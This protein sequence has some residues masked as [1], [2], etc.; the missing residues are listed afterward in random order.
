M[1]ATAAGDAAE[2]RTAEG[3][4]VIVRAEPALG[5][6]RVERLLTV[7]GKVHVRLLSYRDGRF[8]VVPLDDVAPCPPGTPAA[9]Q[10]KKAASTPSSG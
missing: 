5:A 2:G 3:D 10:G 7:D 6:F 1:K 9:G 8:R 4:L